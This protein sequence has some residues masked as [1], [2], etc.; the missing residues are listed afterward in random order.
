MIAEIITIGDEL[1]IGQTV[2]TNGAWIAEELNLIGVTVD[3]IISISDK[4]SHIVQ[5]LNNAKVRSDLIIITGG[6]GPT[7]DDITKE[8]L[9]SYFNTELVLNELVLEKIEG[10]FAHRKLKMLP[11]NQLQ[12][13]LP[14]T[15]KVL[16]NTRGTASGMLFNDAD[17]IIISLPGVPYEMKGLMR[18]YVL[19][20]IDKEYIDKEI[21]HKTVKTVGMGESYL[22]EEI[23]EWEESLV[24]DGIKLAYLPSPGMVKLRLTCAINSRAKSELKI[25]NKIEE[26]K[27]LIPEIIFGYDKDELQEVIGTLL[28]ANKETLAT[29]ESCTGGRIAHLITSVPGSSDYF[30]GSVVSYS[31]E[32]KIN[33]LSVSEVDLKEHWAV[34]ENVVKQM[35]TGVR[36]LMN[37]DYAIATSG[38][39][40]PT[41]GSIEKPVGMVWIAVASKNEVVAQLFQFGNSRNRNIEV[42]SNAALNMLRLQII[43]NK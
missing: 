37:V 8:T 17:K 34:S 27:L 15:C 11:V 5:A 41:G 36:K 21:V 26:L 2:N 1:L 12:A 40:G 18:D 13:M 4:E 7:N 33:Q 14:K 25:N 9:A 10:F 20:M 31:N 42:S 19:P 6:L 38:I 29:A 3:Q 30:K 43:K 28:N 35:A 23:K 24:E 32:I 16:E 22:A 39:A